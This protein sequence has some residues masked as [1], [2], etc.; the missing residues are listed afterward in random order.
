MKVAL[1]EM[2]VRELR[3]DLADVINAAGTRDQ[4]T[5]V[6]S[7]GRRVAAV[8]SVAAAE[9]A[10]S[11]DGQA[12]DD[13]GTAVMYAV[14]LAMLEDRGGTPS[15]T[16]A[17]CF[18]DYANA[19]L[20]ELGGSAE[21]AL[22]AARAVVAESA[23]KVRVPDAVAAGRAGR[24]VV[25]AGRRDHGSGPA[26]VLPARQPGWCR[27][28][29]M[30]TDPCGHQRARQ[31]AGRYPVSRLPPTVSTGRPA[32]ERQ[33]ALTRPD[34]SCYRPWPRCLHMSRQH[35]GLTFW[36]VPVAT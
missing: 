18:E 32:S 21:R 11:T 12:D 10:T 5:F 1:A 25:P 7:R 23:G 20:R 9:Q 13:A 4:V 34:S 14:N 29:A 15:L 33:R 36:Q 27:R 26:R 35:S 28:P 19:L 8:V 2:S 16:P 24:R 3:A 17:E 31:H 22:A 6:T 30:T